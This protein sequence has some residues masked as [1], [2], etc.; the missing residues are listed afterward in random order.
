MHVNTRVHTRQKKPKTSR[1]GQP[2][3]AA[4]LLLLPLV[5]FTLS[6]CISTPNVAQTPALA[7]AMTLP[8]S[9]QQ[10][11]F[12]MNGLLHASAADGGCTDAMQVDQASWQELRIYLN[13]CMLHHLSAI[14][15]DA[16]LA[17]LLISLICPDCAPLAAW[18]S[19]VVATFTA[20]IAH[21]E[22]A[23]QQCGGGGAILD[24]SW[25][26]GWQFKPVCQEQ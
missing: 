20:N 14:V 7:I 1:R 13:D 8:V 9:G 3:W 4:Y 18:I 17:A 25:D 24:L 12:Q 16:N 26:A 2:V 22:Y 5:L 6:S 11:N 21:L 15:A 19:A 10:R 23:S